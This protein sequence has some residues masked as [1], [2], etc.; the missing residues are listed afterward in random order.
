[1]IGLQVMLDDAGQEFVQWNGQWVHVNEVPLPPHKPNGV[2]HREEMGIVKPFSI[3]P[4]HNAPV[5]SPDLPAFKPTGPEQR[6]GSILHPNAV[7]FQ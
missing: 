6:D 3:R 7:P 1:M 4:V 5:A 2:H